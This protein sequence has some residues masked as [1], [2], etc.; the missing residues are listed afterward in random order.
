M[1]SFRSLSYKAYLSDA[2]AAV[3]KETKRRR[4]REAE[5]SILSDEQHGLD[6]DVSLNVIFFIVHSDH[7]LTVFEHSAGWTT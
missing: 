3:P 7:A 2:N 6:P 4:L 5:C 1:V